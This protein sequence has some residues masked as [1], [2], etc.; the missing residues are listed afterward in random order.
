M[1]REALVDPDRAIRGAMLTGF[2][3]AVRVDERSP[4]GTRCQGYAENDCGRRE[5]QLRFYYF[6]GLLIGDP[7]I[8]LSDSV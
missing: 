2:R 3:R 6:V 8:H 7:V 5:Q 1:V 4:N